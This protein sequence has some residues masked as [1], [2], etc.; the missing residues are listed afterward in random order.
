MTILKLEKKQ[1]L[2]QK[3][4]YFQKKFFAE[5]ANKCIQ[6]NIKEARRNFKIALALGHPNAE[7]ALEEIQHIEKTIR[8]KKY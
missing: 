4:T 3:K 7:E 2:N 6:E 5:G 8:Y 1:S